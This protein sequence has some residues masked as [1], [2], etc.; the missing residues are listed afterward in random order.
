MKLSKEERNALVGQK[1]DVIVQDNQLILTNDIDKIRLNNVLRET[2]EELGNLG[3]YDYQPDTSEMILVPGIAEVKD[4]NFAVNIWNGK[5]DV[6]AITPYCHIMKVEE[7]LLEDL[8]YRSKNKKQHESDSEASELVKYPLF[9]ALKGYGNFSG[10]EKLEDGR[11][12]KTDYRY[13]HEWLSA[14]YIASKILN[15]DDEK[16]LK[17][18]HEVQSETPWKISFSRASEKMGK[19][20]SFIAKVLQIKEETV[21]KMERIQPLFLQNKLKQMQNVK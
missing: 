10:K 16:I 19:N 18:I 21:Q 17:L 13:P 3:I 15:H 4:D 2:R 7:N 14:W 11:N 6:W 9:E 1:D 20:L 8:A 5:G 12:A